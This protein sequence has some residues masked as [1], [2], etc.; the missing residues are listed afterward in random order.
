MFR[1]SAS[2]LLYTSSFCIALFGSVILYSAKAQQLDTKQ[3]SA[4]AKGD[5]TV[6]VIVLLHNTKTN[7]VPSSKQK[8]Q[9]LNLQDYIDVV[10]QQLADDMGWVNFNDMVKFKH[11]PAIAKTISP[12]EYKQLA[13]SNLVQGVYTDRSNSLS[14]STSSKTIGV[15]AVMDNAR[16][17]QGYAV[18]IIDSGVQAFH[19]FLASRVVAGACFSFNASCP[20]GTR[21]AEGITAGA[22]C[23]EPS[24][25]HGSH[26]AGIVAGQHSQFNGV[27]K[28]ASLVAINVFST[29]GQGITSRDSDVMQAL[30]W[31][32]QHAERYHIAAVNMSLGG[33]YYSQ[34]CDDSPIKRYVDLLATRGVVTVIAAGNE[35]RDDG[36][37]SPGCISTAVT[38][39]SIEP[40][41]TISAFS[42]SYAQ[43]DIVAPGGGITSSVLNGEYAESSGTS[44]A[45]PHVAGAIALLKSTYPK[46][47][48]QQLIA[49]LQ[50][51]NTFTDPRNNV[52]TPA[53][54]LPTALA[55]LQQMMSSVPPPN[56][57]PVP[58]N[59]PQ[60][61]CRQVIDGIVIEH[62]DA[63]CQPQEG[64]IQW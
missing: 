55:Y 28:E 1:I 27:A 63:A 37:A 48:A 43:L 54:Y 5:G 17:G 7:V 52:Q 62:T 2:L 56:N 3:F 40:E 14:L 60:T 38:V 61:P 15:D 10:Q 64:T 49:A 34:P 16:L 46:A 23:T 19:P 32:Y 59:T 9:W 58:D 18:A 50:H 24:C 39:G 26:V 30:D 22:P 20:G 4:L 25:F 51:G 47:T 36:V 41:G 45:A 12:Q 11:V 44:M 13:A 8:G 53:L 35:G 57:T 31:V 6:P 33:G 29:L 42:N 21:R